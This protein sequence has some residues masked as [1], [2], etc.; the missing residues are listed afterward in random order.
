ML[1]FSS[2]LLLPL[3]GVLLVSS[4]GE[5]STPQ[6]ATDP[7]VE[8][9]YTITD[10]NDAASTPNTGP[11]AN[12]RILKGSGTSATTTY[13]GA[14]TAGT[15][16][17]IPDGSYTYKVPTTQYKR[18]DATQVQLSFHYPAQRPLRA[19]SAIHAEVWVDGKQQG[20]SD[21]GY[22]DRTNTS[23]YSSTSSQYDL[24]RTVSV[25]IP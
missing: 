25:T 17:R 3:L 11:M 19:T 10:T 23:L 21:L 5:D 15:Y 6:P 7:V 12:V 24:V 20:V 16:Q 2:R 14:T 4:C 22:A 13:D 8:L 1:H 18:G 9:R